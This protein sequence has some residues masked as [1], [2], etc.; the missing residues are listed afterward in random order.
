MAKV[1]V[2]SIGNVSRNQASDSYRFTSYAYYSEAQPKQKVLSQYV[3]EALITLE[4]IDRL[5]LIGTAGSDWGGL[6]EYIYA[7]GESAFHPKADMA[8]YDGAYQQ[9]LDDLKKRPRNWETDPAEVENLLRPLLA[10]ISIKKTYAIVL[11]YG[12][13]ERDFAENNIALLKINSHL[14]DGDEL[15]VDMTY[16]LRSLQM[17]QLMAVSY[18]KALRPKVEVKMLLYGMLGEKEF[19]YSP[20]VNITPTIDA[21]TYINATEEFNAFGTIHQIDPGLLRSTLGLTRDEIR[22]L[23]HL[24]NNVSLNDID[25]FV[26]LIDR[27]NKYHRSGHSSADLLATRIFGDLVA[28]FGDLVDEKG[29]VKDAYLLELRL[30]LWHCSKKRFLVSATTAEETVISLLYDLI[31]TDGTLDERTIYERRKA[32]SKALAD[33]GSCAPGTILRSFKETFDS[34]RLIRN[35]LAHPLGKPIDA[36]QTAVDLYGMIEDL[37]VQYRNHYSVSAASGE[38]NRRDLLKDAGNIINH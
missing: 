23:S 5:I 3:S 21:I 31:F 20:I 28:Y 36:D 4:K 13:N 27:A 37:S 7:V 32:C 16:A 2:C 25:D 26:R 10:S 17:F 19:G 33:K 34:V 12:L 14:D 24:S 22:A 8:D 9:Q 11:R 1:L 18:I 15:Y 38:M 6:Y 29:H 35:R 30:A